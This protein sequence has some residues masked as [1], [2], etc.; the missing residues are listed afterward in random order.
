MPQGQRASP[1]AELE[2]M[3]KMRVESGDQVSVLRR[4]CRYHWLQNWLHLLQNYHSMG[5]LLWAIYWSLIFDT[6]TQ[7]V[8]VCARACARV[9]VRACVCARAWV[10]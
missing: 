5:R 8:H 3:L 4:E 1:L 10:G 6:V 2:A 9:R 7:P